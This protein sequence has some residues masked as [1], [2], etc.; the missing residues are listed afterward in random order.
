MRMP[1]NDTSI[2]SQAI[3]L[4]IKIKIK[5]LSE[6]I[7][8]SPPILFPLVPI[9]SPIFPSP[10]FLFPPPSLSPPFSFCPNIKSRDFG[11]FVS[12]LF[13]PHVLINFLSISLPILPSL[14]PFLPFSL[15][16]SVG[17]VTWT[18]C[19]ALSCVTLPCVALPCV[20]CYAFCAGASCVAICAI[21]R[22]ARHLRDSVACMTARAALT[23]CAIT[24][25]RCAL[26][27]LIGRI[28]IAYSLSIFI[29]NTEA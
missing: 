6:H 2:H 18:N 27:W 29:S 10:S 22:P 21:V 16:T 9:S 15:H 14:P 3:F 25:R 23:C 17:L 28:D 20:A 24:L 8:L 11:N 19:V 4:K 12:L 1:M 13:L 26:F 5:T 7:L